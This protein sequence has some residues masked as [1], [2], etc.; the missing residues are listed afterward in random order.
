MAL[1]YW[2]EEV[3]WSLT[4]SRCGTAVVAGVMVKVVPVGVPG[5]LSPYDWLAGKFKPLPATMGEMVME[6][7]VL[8]TVALEAGAGAAWPLN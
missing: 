3:R 8:D 6:P 5:T 2:V 4:P 1:I 7:F